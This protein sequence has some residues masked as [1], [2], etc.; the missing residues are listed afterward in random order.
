[1]VR[2]SNRRGFTL[3][4][5]TVVLAVLVIISTMVV[6]FAVMVS[7]SRQTSTARLEAL[8]DIRV[9]EAVVEGFIEGNTIIDFS[10][11]ALTGYNE[12][13][14]TTTTLSFTKNE[15]EGILSSSGNGIILESVTAISFSRTEDTFLYFCTIKYTVGNGKYSYTF[16]V[17]KEVTNEQG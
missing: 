9:C 2:K 12:S 5:L 1:M 11:D 15:D 10:R 16:C 17:P 6:S 14:E 4:E 7:N 8:Q 3:A 13:S